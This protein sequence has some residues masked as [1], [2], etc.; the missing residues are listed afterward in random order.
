[1]LLVLF[2]AALPSA[3][4]ASP[5][6]PWT[7][8]E[9]EA[10]RGDWTVYPPTACRL[11]SL[12]GDRF[13]DY[14]SRGGYYPVDDSDGG[15]SIEGRTCPQPGCDAALTW[16]HPDGGIVVALL[17]GEQADL[18][19]N[20]AA[21]SQRLPATVEAWVASSGAAKRV[22]KAK[23][24]AEPVACT[25]PQIEAR[26]VRWR[27]ARAHRACDAELSVF[28]G[29][30]VVT[31]ER[32]VFHD[33]PDAPRKG[34]VVRGDLVFTAP[35][36]LPGW[37]CAAYP[38]P[39]GTRTTGWL[40]E[41]DLQAVS[42]LWEDRGQV[43]PRSTAPSWV[44]APAQLGPMSVKPTAGGLTVSV[45]QLIAGHICGVEA[46]LKPARPGLWV[47]EGEGCAA[48]L[49]AFNNGAFLWAHSDC[50]GARANCS[51]AFSLEKAP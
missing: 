21:L 4:A 35:S 22:W 10:A 12:L 41:G 17:T 15:L 38:R 48:T 31:A 9:L 25:G 32:S 19:T 6:A 27:E 3:L 26:T 16:I 36:A 8:A 50:G 20:R 51:G 40:R 1:M 23:E 47:G 11:Q 39:A 13:A 44:G 14:Q 5:M 18:F 42:H 37:S 45:E 49:A 24:A 7:P 30:A 33:R 43:P 2:F 29:P 46:E 28:G 34:F